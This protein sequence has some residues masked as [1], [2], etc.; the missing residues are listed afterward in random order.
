VNSE[1]LR[2]FIIE[3]QAN[4]QNMITKHL[5]EAADF[6][7]VGIAETVEQAIKM[8][9]ILDYDFAI[10]DLQ[11]DLTEEDGF[12]VFKELKKYKDFQPIFLTSNQSP[13]TVYN[14]FLYGGYSYIPKN[15]I[16]VLPQTI[17]FLKD[18][19]VP[20]LITNAV[21]SKLKEFQLSDLTAAEKVVFDE[22][23]QGLKP[24]EISEKLN[25][26]LYTVRSH[27]KNVLKKLGLKN[28]QEALRKLY[29]E[30]EVVVRP[31]ELK[32]S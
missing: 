2:L 9:K 21:H 5:N 10:I 29:Y 12:E 30:D 24:K 27:I 32:N 3:D 28:Y 26:S 31:K 13:S 16:S 8:G 25:I 14:S 15:Y 4:W 17:R 7:V 20:S 22:L 1:F 23:K 6:L 11:L 19:P 18:N